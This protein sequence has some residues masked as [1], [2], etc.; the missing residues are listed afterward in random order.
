MNNFNQRL[1]D[2]FK[3]N[4][5]ILPNKLRSFYDKINQESREGL[6]ESFLAPILEARRN[7]GLFW[8]VPN[9]EGKYILLFYDEYRYKYPDHVSL[10][11]EVASNFICNHYNVENTDNFKECFDCFP[12]GRLEVGEKPGTWMIGFGGDYPEGWD[13]EKLRQNLK[14]LDNYSV[15]YDDH[16]IAQGTNEAI[17]F[18]NCI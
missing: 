6:L 14:I 5:K 3:I 16:W 17:S 18:L 9:E 7:P 13:E 10:W 11:K 1:N 15:E 12:R 2:V 8:I 4:E